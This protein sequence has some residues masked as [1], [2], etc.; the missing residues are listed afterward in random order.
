MK[1]EGSQLHRNLFQKDGFFYLILFLGFTFVYYTIL[2]KYWGSDFVGEMDKIGDNGPFKTIV[3]CIDLKDCELAKDVYVFWGYP[4]LSYLFGKVTF[5]S[6]NY[7]MIGI[8]I[9]AAII[10]FFVLSKLFNSF[11]AIVF[12]IYSYDWIQRVLSGGSEP[13][14]MVFLFLAIYA[15]KKNKNIF[16]VG[17]LI[18][19]SNTI[20]P[21]GVFLLGSIILD[22][23]LKKRFVE[24][25]KLVFTFLIIVIG[26]HLYLN[27]AL[28]KGFANYTNYQ[29][30]WDS[31]SPISFPFVALLNGLYA[32][33]TGI[34]NRIKLW[35]YFLVSLIPI[36]VIFLRDKGLREFG[37]YRTELFFAAAYFLFIV[38]YNTTFWI[39]HIYPRIFLPIAPICIYLIFHKKVYIPFNQKVFILLAAFCMAVLSSIS[40]IGIQN[41]I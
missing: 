14:F 27:Y 16:L 30:S 26:Y 38:S 2:I 37:F 4:I 5:L 9:I 20:R 10:L 3:K 33:D 41:V 39:A 19:I 25:L 28:G 12:N 23:I 11:T 24:I 13:L 21:L 7:A 40:T 36:F 17:L 18:G 31:K 32:L 22:L 8:N 34:L 15:Y 35:I 29:S 1:V 6:I